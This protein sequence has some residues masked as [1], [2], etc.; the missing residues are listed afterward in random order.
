MPR[1]MP[2]YLAAYCWNRSP[3]T[4]TNPASSSQK[5][6]S[7]LLTSSLHSAPGPLEK[8]TASAVIMPSSP[9][10]KNATNESGC[11]PVRYALR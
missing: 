5:S 9:I 2:T 8:L 1:L 7:R 10:V 3:I 6:T 4:Q 11:M